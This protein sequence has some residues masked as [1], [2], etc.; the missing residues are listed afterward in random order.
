[1]GTQIPAT[2]WDP[3]NSFVAL[4]DDAFFTVGFGPGAKLLTIVWAEVNSINEYRY[5]THDSPLQVTSVPDPS[6]HLLLAIGLLGLFGYLWRQQPERM[7]C[8]SDKPPSAQRHHRD[9]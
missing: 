2:T 5:L 3:L 4:N 9:T 1:M 6:S 7:G 8:R